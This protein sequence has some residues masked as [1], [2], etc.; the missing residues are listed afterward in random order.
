MI[1]TIKAAVKIMGNDGRKPIE[2]AAIIGNPV[3]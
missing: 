2:Y 1:G 3:A